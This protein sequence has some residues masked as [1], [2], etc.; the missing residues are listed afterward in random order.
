MAKVGGQRHLDRLAVRGFAVQQHRLERRLGGDQGFAGGNERGWG[1]PQHVA[2]P[3]AQHDLLGLD[4]VA[5]GERRLELV[6]DRAG[7]APR[8]D[9]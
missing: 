4:A 3:A 9:G 1:H 7:I 6:L 5:L 8:V 2:R